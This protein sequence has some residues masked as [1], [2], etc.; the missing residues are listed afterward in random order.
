[1][2]CSHSPGYQGARSLISLQVFRRHIVLRDL[3]GVNFSHVCVGCIFYAS[4][5]SGATLL[6]RSYLDS[7]A[8]CPLTCS[9]FTTCCTLGTVDATCAARARFD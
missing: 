4:R 9:S 5:P 1:M 8:F 2:A 6:S 7:V 3:F